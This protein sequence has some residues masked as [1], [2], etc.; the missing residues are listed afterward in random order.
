ME[1][2]SSIKYDLLILTDATYSIGGYLEA[3]QISLPRIIAVTA[4]TDS[5]ARI[6]VLAYRDYSSD[7]LAHWSGWYGEDGGVNRE[8]LIHFAKSLE[9]DSGDGW[10]ES[11]KTGF[12]R[13]HSVMRSDA[14]TLILHYTNVPPYIPWNVYPDGEKEQ[15][16]LLSG[17]LGGTREKLAQVFVIVGNDDI[18]TVSPYVFMCHE[19]LGSCF[20][21]KNLSPNHISALTMAIILAWLGISKPGASSYIDAT[22]QEYKDTSRID[23]VSSEDDPTAKPYLLQIDDMCADN[24]VRDN[25][26]ARAVGDEELGTCIVPR[27]T[28]VQDFAEQYIT[29]EKYRVI[30]VEH[31]TKIIEEDVVSIAINPVFGSLWRTVCNDRDN[32]A[33]DNL[34]GRLGR[35]IERIH[36]VNQKLQMKAWLDESHNHNTE[37]TA[38]IR[39]V[40]QEDRY[41]CIFLDP[42]E[43]WRI[44]PGE[45][46]NAD[47][48]DE[49]ARHITS[50]TCDELLEIRRSCDYPIFRRLG[51]VLT[52]FTYVASENAMPA[53]IRA[54]TNEDVP[55]VP[56]SLAKEKYKREFWKILLHL[57]LP[58][59]K[60]AARTAAL[61]AALS[62]RMGIKPL[63]TA[64]D[65]EMISWSNQWNRL[66]IPDIWKTSCLSLILDADK[67]F[68]TRRKIG[69]VHDDIPKDAYF[70]S[71][72][73]RQLFERLQPE[74][75][76]VPIGPLVL[77]RCCKYPRSVTIM[78][79]G[80]MCGICAFPENEFTGRR[81][82]Q[83]AIHINV[84]RDHTES[85]EA[86]WVE[87][88]V[89]T[90]R[91][92][93]IVYDVALLECLN[94]VI[95]P[96]EYRPDDFSVTK[97]ECPACTD[98]R[99]TIISLDTTPTELSRENGTGWL[100]RNVDN[101]LS[102]P[103]DKRSLFK[104]ISAAGI[105]DFAAKVEILPNS[106][107]SDLIYRGKV[108][109]NTADIKAEL[110]RWIKSRRAEAGTCSLC[111][112]NFKKD[113]LRSAC[114]RSA[115][116][117]PI[118]DGCRRNWH[119]VNARGQIIRVGALYCPFC[120]RR[121]APNAVPR[122]AGGGIT[123]LGNL[124]HAVDEA[125]TWIYAW[126]NECGF[127]R[128]FAERTCVQGAP[129]ELR[130]WRCD[131]CR[132]REERERERE[133]RARERTAATPSPKIKNCPGCDTPTEKRD[134]C[135]HIHCPMPGCGVDWCFFC[136]KRVPEHDIYMHM[137]DEHGGWYDGQLE[138]YDG[139][140]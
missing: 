120:R 98:G 17:K 24:I 137:S 101:K 29:D 71:P 64:A 73:D 39:G 119:D 56:L 104:T 84:S 109:H 35:S 31:L 130:H 118:C 76:K 75:S 97:F 36:D 96:A 12:A 122:T 81:T 134:G 10:S 52:R 16:L 89:S 106:E 47:H 41:P 115:C 67:S 6:G 19:T 112:S 77:C 103:F 70:L 20:E 90:C 133:E 128:R 140:E 15:I 88:V 50:F 108:V 65:T 124:R 32:A 23:Q 100:L 60:L 83:D 85:T 117:Q 7:R 111:F 68:E 5:F 110:S 57:V 139:V 69:E 86:T 33:R 45:E 48:D 44:S 2:E 107:T 40:A 80:H 22:L 25:I 105:E 49:P 123:T 82:K 113:A 132:D 43:D 91:A 125:D 95:W 18:P 14:K 3:L 129:P 66:D 55:R 11:A 99:E 26:R 46:G 30:V 78:A 13:A 4:L 37:I 28:P 116:Q 114:G 53:H 61:L 79:D 59:T 27:A 121:P 74:K 21:I 126:C 72:G 138:A 136:G 127:A 54:M 38:I 42:T 102:N 51:R 94:R 58:G 62:V 9:F 1:G 135:D 8:E 34:V 87:C 63:M 131:E 92:Q 93:F